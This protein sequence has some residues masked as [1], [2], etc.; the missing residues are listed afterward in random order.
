MG[1]HFDKLQITERVLLK[2]WLLQLSTDDL[3]RR[4]GE[5]AGAGLESS[6]KLGIVAS[7]VILVA[8]IAGTLVWP[9]IL[10]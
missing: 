1:I 5:S 3:K 4:L 2:E 10:R 7:A 8:L 9:G 6:D